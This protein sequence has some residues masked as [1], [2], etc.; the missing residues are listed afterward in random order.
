MVVV[1]A[2]LRRVLVSVLRVVA[3]TV[4]TKGVSSLT[5]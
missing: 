4:P 1:E 5:Q 3:V 2:V